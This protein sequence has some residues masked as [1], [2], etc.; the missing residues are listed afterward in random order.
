MLPE[1]LFFTFAGHLEKKISMIRTLIFAACFLF[2]VNAFS[3]IM[4]S[5]KSDRHINQRASGVMLQHGFSFY[6]LPEG[7]AYRPI[8]LAYYKR[9][10]IFHTHRNINLALEIGPQAG[11][12]FTD[13]LNLELGML[14]YLSA[15]VSI[16][17]WDMISFIAGAGPHFISVETGKQANGFIFSDNLFLTYRRKLILNRS[18]YE[19]SIYGGFRHLSNAGIKQPNDG[20]DN[21][22]VGLGFVKLI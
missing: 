7:V 18:P 8:L 10:P 22:M 5:R 21:I 9:Y 6:D 11:I 20:I 12:G 15:N 17:N 2:S 4:V 3:Q 16:T 13:E 1:A 14:V 19:V